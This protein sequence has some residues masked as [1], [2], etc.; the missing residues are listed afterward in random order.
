MVADWYA[1]SKITSPAPDKFP[2]VN[3]WIVEKNMVPFVYKTLHDK[4]MTK[5]A[6]YI[7]LEYHDRN[8]L[9]DTTTGL[10]VGLAQGQIDPREVIKEINSSLRRTDVP[11]EVK[12]YLGQVKRQLLFREFAYQA[13]QHQTYKQPAGAVGTNSQQYKDLVQAQTGIPIIDAA[14]TD[15]T[16]NGTPHN[17]ARLLLARHAV[18]TLNIDPTAVSDLYKANLKD[19]DPVLNTYNIVSAS[20]GA[21]FAEPYY[22]TSNAFTAGKKLDPTGSYQKKFNQT[23]KKPSQEELDTISAGNEYWQERWKSGKFDHTDTKLFPTKDKPKGKFFIDT[24]THKLPVKGHFGQ[25]Y[26]AYLNNE[27]QILS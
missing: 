3:N 18:R 24:T 9:A 7:P 6:Q 5:Q 15:L 10:S 8:N 23:P 16:E 12:E 20:S 2:D 26:K 14:V 21:T 27:E 17:R 11:L 22:R 13:L 19:Y 4:A 25:F 1:V